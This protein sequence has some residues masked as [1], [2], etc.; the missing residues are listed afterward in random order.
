M[1]KKYAVIID[2]SGEIKTV[3]P[4]P[5]DD[6]WEWFSEVSKEAKMKHFGHLPFPF[7]HQYDCYYDDDSVEKDM[8]VNQKATELFNLGYSIRG[9]IIVLHFDGK[10]NSELLTSDQVDKVKNFLG[11]S[12]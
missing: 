10:D 3:E 2:Y 9:N 7:D 12:N 4:K 6:V 1:D 8:P 5:S 11:Y